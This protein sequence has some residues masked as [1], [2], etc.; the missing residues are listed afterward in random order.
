MTCV[1]LQPSYIPWR[2]YFDQIRRSDVFVYYDDVQYD[3][4]GWRNRNRIKTANGPIWLTIPV[5]SKGN[6]AESLTIGEIKIDWRT[7]WPKKHLESLRHAYARTPHF[8]ASLPLLEEIYSS[9][10]DLLVDFLLESTQLICEA[11]GLGDRKF[12]RSSDLQARGVKTERLLAILDE[13]GADHYLSGP[14]ARDYLEEDRFTQAGKSLEYMRYDYS[15]YLQLH[16]PYDPAVSILD[17]LFMLGVDGIH[18]CWAQSEAV[19]EAE[20]HTPGGA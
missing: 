8:K 4:H 3:K 16:P 5:H 1:V 20:G 9:R 17:T 10:H 14:S 19:S 13:V 2:G 7:P 18:S 11:I 15:P 12:V 6:V